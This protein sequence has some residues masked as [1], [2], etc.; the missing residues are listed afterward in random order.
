M[1]SEDSNVKV[2]RLPDCVFLV[3]VV[4]ILQTVPV[5]RSAET[6]TN[7]LA[8]NIGRRTSNKPKEEKHIA[9]WWDVVRSAATSLTVRRCAVARLAQHAIRSIGSQV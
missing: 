5:A 6:D 4:P 7:S 8:R 9:S 3:V 2:G 1:K